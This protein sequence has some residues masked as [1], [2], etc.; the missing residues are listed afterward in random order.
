MHGIVCIV[1][2]M[3][4]N[5][6]MHTYHA[7][8]CTYVHTYITCIYASHTY[9]HTCTCRQTYTR[10]HADRHTHVYIHTDIHTCTCTQT[11]TRVH[12]H[13][14]CTYS[15][16][17]THMYMHTDIHTCRNKYNGRSL[18][19]IQACVCL[20]ICK[21]GLRI[22]LVEYSVCNSRV[23]FSRFPYK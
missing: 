10:V 8:I 19:K 20:I 1:H 11:Y 16:S 21:N 7:Y 12:A 4:I 13:I 2:I 9:I 14:Q 17:H 5:T 18:D 15:H 6:Y 22:K 3:Y 23:L